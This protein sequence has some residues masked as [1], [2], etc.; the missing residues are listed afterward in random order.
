MGTQL[1][2]QQQTEQIKLFV[3]LSVCLLIR[4]IVM[5]PLFTCAVCLLDFAFLLHCILHIFVIFS[6]V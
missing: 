3:S 1:W 2:V 4:L 5:L 6:F